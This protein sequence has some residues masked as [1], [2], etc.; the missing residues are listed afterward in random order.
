MADEHLPFRLEAVVVGTAGHLAPGLEEMD[1][2]RHVRVPPRPRRVPSRWA[3]AFLQA[4]A[5]RAMGAVDVEG[6]EIVAAHARAPRAVDVSDDAAVELEGA[7]GG[8]V[9]I[10]LVRLAVLVPALGN[11]RGAEAGYAFDVAEQVVGHVTRMAEPVD[12]DARA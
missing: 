6:N 9:D 1:R 7:I 10:G 2:L 11:M 5:R 8:V 3:P 12:D 4:G